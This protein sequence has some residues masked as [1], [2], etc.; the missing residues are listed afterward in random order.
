MGWFQKYYSERNWLSINLNYRGK[1]YKI[2][3]SILTVTNK[4]ECDHLLKWVGHTLTPHQS[5]NLPTS[6]YM[7]YSHPFSE[8]LVILYYLL[9]YILWQLGTSIIPQ[10]WRKTNDNNNHTLFQYIIN[11]T[12]QFNHSTT[13]IYIYILYKSILDT[14]MYIPC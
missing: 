6:H 11:T 14:A 3:N 10:D 13:S 12:T 4:W 2:L 7:Q 5:H 8:Q 9:F 1:D